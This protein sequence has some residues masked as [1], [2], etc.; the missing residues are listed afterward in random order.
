MSVLTL[1]D[2][3]KPPFKWG[4]NHAIFDSQKKITGNIIFCSFLNGYG[5]RADTQEEWRLQQEYMDFIVAAMNEKCEREIGGDYVCPECKKVFNY[6]S[7]SEI[8]ADAGFVFCPHCGHR[9][10]PAPAGKENK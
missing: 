1:K 5:D 6:E 3:L 10:L 4:E 9:P 2:V 8:F 7:L